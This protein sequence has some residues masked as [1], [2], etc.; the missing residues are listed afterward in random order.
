[1]V[2]LFFIVAAVVVVLGV[3][4]H[5]R[6]G[7]GVHRSARATPFWLNDSGV[8]GSGDAGW[9]GVDTGGDTGGSLG[10]GFGDGGGCSGGDGGGGGSC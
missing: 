3:V 4:D 8:S 5:F 6:P 2:V 1:M 9:A 10:S 7:G